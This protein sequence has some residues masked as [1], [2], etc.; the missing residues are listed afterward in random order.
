MPYINIKITKENG[1][2]TK[3]QK[4]RLALGVTEL[5]EQILGRNGKNAVVVIDE[6]EPENYAVGGETISQKI[7]K[8]V[9]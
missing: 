3:E 4:E 1:T 6:I 7:Q 9:R 2:P 5:F 8:G